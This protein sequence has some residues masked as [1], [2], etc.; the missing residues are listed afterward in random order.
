MNIKQQA[1]KEYV[2]T[3]HM[4]E[5]RFFEISAI[6]NGYLD[7]HGE[8]SLPPI[9]RWWESVDEVRDDLTFDPS[10]EVPIDDLEMTVRFLR[11]TGIPVLEMREWAV[12][13]DQR[14][15]ID[16]QESHDLNEAGTDEFIRSNSS[17][18]L[19]AAYGSDSDDEDTWS[20]VG[21]DGEPLL[22]SYGTSPDG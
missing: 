16:K 10:H 21:L 11:E 14:D 20:L 3:E 22:S 6:L 4:T 12:E 2:M 18:G 13:A 9:D 19:I 8:T 15:W 1:L 17:A 7:E 5:Q